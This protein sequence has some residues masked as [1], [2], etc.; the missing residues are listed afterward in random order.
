[1]FIF[2][3][4]LHTSQL[5]IQAYREI[6]ALS[7]CFTESLIRGFLTIIVAGIGRISKGHG[8]RNITLEHCRFASRILKSSPGGI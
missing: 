6:P 4:S 2:L 1:M 7:W 3:L 8:K 5:V